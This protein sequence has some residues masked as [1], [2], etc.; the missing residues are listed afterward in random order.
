MKSN[1]MQRRSGSGKFTWYRWNATCDKCGMLFQDIDTETSCA[2]DL[3][4]T[5]F[6]VKCMREFMNNN[7]SY[8]VAKE[9]YKPEV[10]HND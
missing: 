6:C 9:K 3:E 10:I 7:I 5:D 4:E 1:I 8:E 2:P